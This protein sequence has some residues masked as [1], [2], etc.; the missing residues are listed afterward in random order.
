LRL[1][2]PGAAALLGALTLRSAKRRLYLSQGGARSR[3]RGGRPR[4]QW[5]AEDQDHRRLTRTSPGRHPPPLREAPLATTT[6]L[7]PPS[8]SARSSCFRRCLPRGSG[9]CGRNR[10]EPLRTGAHSRTIGTAMP[11][12]QA[13]PRGGARALRFRPSS[14]DGPARFASH[15]P[16]PT[17]RARS[18]PSG[19]PP[20]QCFPS[21][22]LGDRHG[23]SPHA[24]HAGCAGCVARA[25][26]SAAVA[27]GTPALPGAVPTPPSGAGPPSRARP[28]ASS[29]NVAAGTCRPQRPANAGGPYSERGVSRAPNACSGSGG[30][31]RAR[32]GS[33]GR[34]PEVRQPDAEHPS[35]AP[36]GVGCTAADRAAHPVQSQLHMD[37]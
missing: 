36:V 14:P 34:T 26:S 6:H 11:G 1:R 32:A 4:G 18:D 29:S 22:A 10:F 27:S 33:R 25:V 37:S 12:L 16:A 31:A 20:A 8:G 19:G 13:M 2:E 15:T 30:G 28:S 17:D 5:S 7:R 24:I 3:L 35:A 23:F 9:G 21:A